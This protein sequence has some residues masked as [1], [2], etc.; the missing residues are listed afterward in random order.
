VLVGRSAGNDRTDESASEIDCNRPPRRVR[1]EPATRQTHA[2]NQAEYKRQTQADTSQRSAS[3]CDYI[4]CLLKLPSCTMMLIVELC[5]LLEERERERE[6]TA[7]IVC[8]RV[9]VT[10]WCPSV[11]PICHRLLHAAAAGL[12]LLARQE[13]SIDSGGRLAA[14][15]TAANANSVTLTQVDQ[16]CY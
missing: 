4:G 10:V 1:K 15:R 7:R 12:L 6:R 5:A 8:G 9:C 14:R 3:H 2:A 16:T 13:I 11:C